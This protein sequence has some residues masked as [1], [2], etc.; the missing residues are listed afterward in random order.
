LCEVD[1]VGTIMDPGAPVDLPLPWLLTN[2]RAMRV[3]GV[4]DAVWTRLLDVPAALGARSYASE[5]RLTFA[6]ADATRPGGPADGVFTVE[7][8]P[9]GAA[10]TRGGEPDLA[11]DVSALSAAWLGG[12]RCSTLA[13]AGQLEE[14]TPGALRRADQ[15]LACEPQP[16]PFTWF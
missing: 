3:K 4:P 6:V 2:N 9:G 10:V 14:R 13:A 12:V 15:F 16:F 7:G 5:D 8:G 11:G 1:L